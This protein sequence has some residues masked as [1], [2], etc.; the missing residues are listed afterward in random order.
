MK[1]VI[2]RLLGSI[3]K[4]VALSTIIAGVAYFANVSV[5]MAFTISF[6]GQFVLSYFYNSYLEFKAAKIIKEQ[7][8][9]ELEILARVTFTIPCAACKVDSEVI[10]NPKEDNHFVCPNCKARNSVYLSAEAALVTEPIKVE[11]I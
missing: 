6:I 7:Q 1:E 10:V 2:I 3:L 11:A 4:A 9:K 8:L 5:L